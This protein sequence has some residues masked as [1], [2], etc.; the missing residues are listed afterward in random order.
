[1]S[2]AGSELVEELSQP[3]VSQDISSS[4]A[5]LPFSEPVSL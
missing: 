3:S 5:F 4:L 2:W 1:M